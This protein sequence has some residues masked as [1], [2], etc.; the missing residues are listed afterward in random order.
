MKHL[1]LF[2]V[3]LVLISFLGRVALSYARPEIL[4]RKWLTIAPHIISSLLLISGILL[5]VEGG[6][7]AGNYDWIL[8]KIGAL[9][10]FIALGIVTLK[11]TDEKRWLA[12]GGAMLC[13]FYI[14]NVAMTKSVGFF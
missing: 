8:A 7:L 1:H 2:F 10:G 14:I 4:Q 12:F 6:W 3:T 11:R 5:T 9:C 13:F